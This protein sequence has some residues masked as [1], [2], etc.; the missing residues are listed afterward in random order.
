MPAGVTSLTKVDQ[1]ILKSE[2]L[3]NICQDCVTPH[4]LSSHSP[5]CHPRLEVQGNTGNSQGSEAKALISA[6]DGRQ[7]VSLSNSR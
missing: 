1:T 6:V 2:L 3:G 4:K 5:L 7:M